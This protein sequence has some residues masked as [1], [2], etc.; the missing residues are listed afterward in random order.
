MRD[1]ATS[2]L[3]EHGSNGRGAGGTFNS[4]FLH[5][6]I[7]YTMNLRIRS[8]MDW[9]SKLNHMWCLCHFLRAMHRQKFHAGSIFLN[10]YVHRSRCYRPVYLSAES[11]SHRCLISICVFVNFM[12]LQVFV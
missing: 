9:N 2:D 4:H 5:A 12:H 11:K 6:I 8:F 1:R 10:T 3:R 7:D